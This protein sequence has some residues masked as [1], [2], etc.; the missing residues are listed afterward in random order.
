LSAIWRV[1]VTEFRWQTRYWQ[2]SGAEQRGTVSAAMLTSTATGGAPMFTGTLSDIS[3][4][5][6]GSLFPRSHPVD[7][8][9]G[10]PGE[11]E[12]KP[13][14]HNCPASAAVETTPSL[15]TKTGEHVNGRCPIACLFSP[16][17]AR[18]PARVEL[19]ACRRGERRARMK[20]TAR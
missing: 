11:D 7:F 5:G 12:R 3:R 1:D 4:R 6:A 13:G 19:P 18:A 2:K 10:K 17:P 8:S 9:Y 20:F 14:P 16:K 15:S